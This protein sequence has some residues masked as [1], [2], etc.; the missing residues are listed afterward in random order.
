MRG[1]VMRMIVMMSA[2]SMLQPGRHSANRLLSSGS[3]DQ[4]ASLGQRP[5]QGS[6]TSC[7][8]KLTLPHSLLSQRPEVV[9]RYTEAADCPGL[10]QTVDC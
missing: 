7:L 5:Q 4:G 9:P 1:N 8:L 2:C 10:T 6:E 3:I